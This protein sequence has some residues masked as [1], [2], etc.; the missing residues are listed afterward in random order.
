MRNRNVK[1]KTH[2]FYYD[3]T[4]IG[5]FNFFKKLNFQTI[6]QTE[7]LTFSTG[8]AVNRQLTW[9]NMLICFSMVLFSTLFRAINTNVYFYRF[10]GYF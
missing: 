3:T 10:I 1:D 7:M 8:L 2:A 5:T 6:E 4:Q 9:Y